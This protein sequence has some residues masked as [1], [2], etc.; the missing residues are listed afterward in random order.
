MFRKW[1]ILYVL[2]E[3]ACS[4]SLLMFKLENAESRNPLEC[5]ICDRQFKNPL[6]LNCHHSFCQDCIR[7]KS[8]CPV[9]DYPIEGEAVSQPMHFCETCQQALCNDCRQ[10]AHQAK[11]FSTHR[12]VPLEERSRV[13]G[14]INCPKHNEPYILHSLDN[15]SLACIVCFNNSA[16][17]SRHHLVHIDAAHKTGCE[18]LDKAAT[19]LRN[20][21]D[22]VR[23]QL[24]LRKRLA[25]ELSDS[26]SVASESIKQTCQE[27]VDAILSV[28]DRLLKKLD[29]TKNIREKHFNDQVKYL[30]CLQPSIRLYLLGA[31]I[32]CSSASK[33]DFLQFSNE[34]LKRIQV[35]L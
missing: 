5:L 22:D 9:C 16:I 32:F 18:K 10:N 29:E 21:Q 14:K 27:M 23:E 33:I 26:Y 6:R 17:D 28:K 31:S 15:R 25:S 24:Q 20:F 8:C 35:N 13:K 19:K 7:D 4:S 34:L 11:M 2:S 30:I 12:L 3:M 1:S